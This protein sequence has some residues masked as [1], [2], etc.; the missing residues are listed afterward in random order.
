M[1]T[2]DLGEAIRDAGLSNPFLS[3]FYTGL[4]AREDQPPLHSYFGTPIYNQLDT[5]PVKAAKLL[6]YMANIWMPSMATRQGAIGYTGRAI[7]GGE[8]RWGREVSAGQALGRWFGVNIVSVSPEQTRAQASVRIQDLRKEQSRIEANPSYDEED[9]A[10]YTK[11]LNEKL[12]DIAQEAPAAVLPITKAK[13]KDTVYEALQ[14]MAA[15]GILHTAPPSRSVEIAGTPFKM[16]MDQYSRYLEQ[17]SEI[18]RNKLRPLVESPTWEQ[19]SDK[20]KA[21]AVSGIVA[22]A[23]KGIRQRIKVEIARDNQ[24]KI[25]EAKMAR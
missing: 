3:M 11:R 25:R 9:K 23:R 14:A 12:A 21:D 6:E 16:T 20:R 17:T 7:A 5:A 8:D 15:K 13:G 18:A 10:A 1:K 2:A 24:E 22:N 19:M 4:S